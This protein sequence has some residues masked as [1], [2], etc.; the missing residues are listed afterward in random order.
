MDFWYEPYKTDKTSQGLCHGLHTYACR[1]NTVLYVPMH[2]LNTNQLHS[3]TSLKPGAYP[4][5]AELTLSCPVG[6]HMLS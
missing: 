3:I 1:D 6:W 4:H 2:T 5:A